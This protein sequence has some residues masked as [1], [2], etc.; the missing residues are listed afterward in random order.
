[1]FGGMLVLGRVA[2][3]DVTAFETAPEVDPSVT[4]LQTFL[5]AVGFRR[6]V[7]GRFEM[8]A[9]GCH[10]FASVNAP[11]TNGPSQESPPE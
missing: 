4:H 11:P 2:A 3:A 5:A 7:V 8:L 9:G 10:F 6:R 1:M